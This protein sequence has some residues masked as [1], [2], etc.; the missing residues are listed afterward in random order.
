[1]PRFYRIL[2]GSMGAMLLRE[3]VTLGPVPEDAN[4][5][6][7]EVVQKLHA[8]YAAAGAGIVETLTLGANTWTLS[9]KGREGDLET[10]VHAAVANAKSA[11][12]DRALVALSAGPTG[13]MLA[14]LG[15]AEP[16]TVYQAY[17]AQMRSGKAA[18]A[19]LAMI[20]TQNDLSEARVC[21]LAAKAAGL[22]FM[23]SMTMEMGGRTMM[24]DSPEAVTAVAQALG[25]EAVGVNCVGDID[26]L[27]PVIRRMA[28]STHLPILVMP[29][30]GKPES[31]NGRNVYSLTPDEYESWVLQL[32]QAGAELIGGCC[33]TGPEHIE[34]VQRLIEGKVPTER[35]QGETRLT[36]A[37]EA[38]PL[39]QALEAPFFYTVEADA[40]PYDVM[41]DLLDAEDPTAYV[42][43]ISGLDVDAVK[44]LC[45][46]A[47]ASVTVPVIFACEDEAVLRS[48]LLNTPGVCGIKTSLSGITQEMGAVK[49]EI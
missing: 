37:R 24:G 28:D 9:D 31:V 25:A 40:D 39:S 29:N 21:A 48:A 3:G 15:D 44:D 11:V 45:L 23:I 17:L 36:T 14:P 12:G 34:R 49:V 1:M 6:H 19:D 20:E 4:L 8:A 43:D 30:A 47:L 27:L 7:P 41:D 16:E 46:T 38:F 2:D 10:L 42:M 13:A 5:T 35:P 32:M 18:G 22:P 26:M 33:G